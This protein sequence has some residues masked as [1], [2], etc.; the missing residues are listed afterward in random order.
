MFSFALR[1][2]DEFRDRLKEWPQICLL[3]LQVP[4]I[5]EAQSELVE[6]IVDVVNSNHTADASAN[7]TESNDPPVVV[8]PMTVNPP[9]SLPQDTQEDLFS[10][11]FGAVDTGGKRFSSTDRYLPGVVC[12][13]LPNPAS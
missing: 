11:G 2:L 13:L 12:V 7:F 6:F 10:S 1:A 4:H 8:L 5:Q 9:L 3:I